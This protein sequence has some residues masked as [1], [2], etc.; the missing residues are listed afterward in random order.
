[1][2][3]ETAEKKI[4]RLRQWVADLQQGCYVNCVYCGHRYGPDDVTPTSAVGAAPSMAEALKR[5]VESCPE[6]PMA[7][8][9]AKYDA[10]VDAL[11]IEPCHVTGMHDPTHTPLR[12]CEIQ[13][14]D[15]WIRAAKLLGWLEEDANENVTALTAPRRLHPEKCGWCHHDDPSGEQGRAK[16]REWVKNGWRPTLSRKD[17]R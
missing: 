2:K 6:H 15:A 3:K 12:L 16:L 8:L 5:H 13:R 7:K 10:L 9:K 4:A 17:A 14:G 1:M 11:V